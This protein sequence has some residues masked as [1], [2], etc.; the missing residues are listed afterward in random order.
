MAARIPVAVLGATGVVGQRFVARL[1]AHPWFEIAALAASEKSAGK[2]YR[3]AC[4]WRL[5]GTPYAG[6]GERT[7]VA[8]EPARC[9]APVAFSALD[10][11]PARAI[12]PAFAAAGATVFSNASAW[13]LESDVP[14][15]VPEVNADHLEL[16]SAQR[17]RRGWRGGIVCNP[18]CTAALLVL[19]VAPLAESFGIE[20]VVMTSMQALSGAG[21]PGVASLD[22]LGNVVPFIRHE[23]EKLAAESAKIL[24]HRSG[25]AIAPAPFELSAA[26]NRVPVIDGHTLAISLRLAGEPSLEVVREALASWTPRTAGSGLPSAP[27]HPLKLHAAEDRPQPRLDVDEERGMLVHVGRVRRCPVLGVKLVAMGHNVERGA[28]G[29]S[30]LDAELARERGFLS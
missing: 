5:P 17:E 20:A 27:L 16:L 25:A 30:V 18:N 6:L 29:A 2:R 24:G 15:L 12:E 7:L 13:R 10:A 4:A 23:E 28:A 14:L 21:H 3:E 11:E 1:A 19:A 9:A 8:C 22:A 26:C